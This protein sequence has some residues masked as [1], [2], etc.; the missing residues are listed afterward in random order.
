MHKALLEFFRTETA[1]GIVMIAAAILALA[2]SNSPAGPWYQA[3]TAPLTHAVN[4][5][6]MVFFFFLVG[7]EL[8]KEMLTGVLSDKKQ[9]MLPLVAAIGGMVAPALLFMLINKDVPEHWNGWAIASATD[10]AF[11]VCVLTLVAK[12]APPALKIFL[13][14]IAIFDDLGAILIIALFYGGEGAA[15]YTTLAGVVMGFVIPARYL[16]RTI[17]LLH[18]WV[19]FLVLPIFAFVT[20]GVDIRG[21]PV[22]AF[23]SHLPLGVALGLFLGKQIGIFGATW[24]LVRAGFARL[25]EGTSWRQVYG[26]SI[27]AGIGFTMSLFIGQLAFSDALLQEQVKIGVI[28]GSLLATGWGWLVLSRS[29]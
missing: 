28:V 22:S 21:I 17:H 6:L 27:I 14:A 29:R 20:A 24:M 9:I 12:S 11:A 25:P 26:V 16:D 8:K 7:M 1:G 19:A 4:N 13:L 3:T 18:P 10:I 2:A 5:V 15:H 23:L